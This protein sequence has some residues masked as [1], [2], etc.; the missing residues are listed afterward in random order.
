MTDT[1]FCPRSLEN[2]GGPNSPF[3]PPMNGEAHWREDGTCSYC[4]SLSPE[5]L[6]AAIDAGHEITPTDKSYKIY[7]VT[8]TARH[9]KF[10]FQHLSP[11]EQ[12][13]FVDL[14]NAQGLDRGLKLGFP[15]HFYVLPFFCSRAVKVA[16][17]PA[18]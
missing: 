15:G 6:F 12:Q 5:Q 18:E 10:Y 14:A 17:P 9:A 16:E 11:E 8:D 2:G 1:F 13:R 3:K 7:V 4:G